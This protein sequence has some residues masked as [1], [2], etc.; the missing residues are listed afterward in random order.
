MGPFLLILFIIAIAVAIVVFYKKDRQKKTVD[1]DVPT[2]NTVVST[3]EEEARIKAEEEA[4]LKA[5]E[6]YVSIF[7][8][9]LSAFAINISN[10][11]ET[12]KYFKQLYDEAYNQF[13]NKTSLNNLPILLIE[14]NFPHFYKF[15]EIDNIDASYKSL[16]GWLFALQLA[17]LIPLKKTNIFK[18]GYEL[19]GYN[20]YSNIY[21]Y[22]FES[23]PNIARKVAATL[24][25]AMR[26]KLH[27]DT[28]KMRIEVGG[29]K[30]NETLSKLSSQSRDNVGEKDF[31][32]DFR[33]FM[34]TAPGPYAPGYKTRPDKTYP[35]EEKDEYKNLQI[36]RDIHEDIITK[37]NLGNKEYEQATVQAIAD[38]E[39]ESQHLFGKD[40]QTKNYKFHPVFGTYNIGIE[41]QELG[42]VEKLVG[43]TIYA[44]SGSRGILQSATVS[45]KQYG[46][47]RPGCS[48]EKEA[49]PNSSTDDRRNILTNF[50]IED[51][52]GSPT[53]YYDKKGNWVYK[54]AINS[55][56]DFEKAAKKS[57]WANS[58]PSGHSSGIMGGAMGLIEIM[59]DKADKILKA[60]NQFAVNRTIA[61]YHWTSDTRN[62][63]VLGS[64][65]NAVAHAA[66]NYDEL[67]ENARKEINS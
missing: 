41:L 31:F 40:R 9:C 11:S 62:G 64:A 43:Y 24:Y 16:I 26:G 61:R 47:L 19:G 29:T 15:G 55:P 56:S 59:P 20:K 32:I 12:Y 7:E 50:E 6:E 35:N 34:P 48:W 67:L 27:P 45:P 14:D 33:E 51:G 1:N 17:E 66:S 13:Y 60:A 4:R 38:K 10:G 8:N 42:A 52:D 65:Q 2:D 39:S 28:D 54:D 25:C 23:D 49:T 21:G 3:E 53:G 37:Y 57:L 5:E 22:T 63:R 46:R 44:S 58:Y 36:D 18:I 30:Y